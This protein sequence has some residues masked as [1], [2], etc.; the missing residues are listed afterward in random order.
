MSF[1]T[2]IT[3]LDQCGCLAGLKQ[4]LTP[5][6]EAPHLRYWNVLNVLNP[7]NSTT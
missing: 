1:L 3:A 6:N 4:G 2:H 5:S 7:Q